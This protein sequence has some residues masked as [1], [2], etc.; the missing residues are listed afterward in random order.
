M[1]REAPL[2]FQVHHVLLVHRYNCWNQSPHSTILAIFVGTLYPMAYIE[3]VPL[4]EIKSVMQC[5]N[6]HFIGYFSDQLVE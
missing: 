5:S 2:V 6:Q 4:L 3:F 1:A